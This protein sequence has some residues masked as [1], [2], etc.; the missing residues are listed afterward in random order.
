MSFRCLA[1]TLESV[2]AE[3]RRLS[4]M[5]IADARSLDDWYEEARKLQNAL[6]GDGPAVPHFHFIM[7]YLID[8]DIRLKDPTYRESQESR[9]RDV[10]AELSSNAE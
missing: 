6:S 8:A 5:R 4:A 7:H 3:L 10:I 2:V 9:L 1:Y